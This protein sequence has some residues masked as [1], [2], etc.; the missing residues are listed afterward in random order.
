MKINTVLFDLDGVLI[1]TEH[2]YTEYWNN[3]GKKYGMSDDF[4][5]KVKGRIVQNI[6]DNEL[7]H[8]SSDDAKWLR[9]DVIKFDENIKLAPMKGVKEFVKMLYDNNFK[10]GLFT[11]SPPSKAK[12]ALEELDVIDFF[13]A[14]VSSGDIKNGKPDPEGYLLAAKRLNSKPEEC[15]VIEDSIM[16]IR[17]GR[18]AGMRVIGISSTL[19]AE[20]LRELKLAYEIIPGLENPESV[21]KLLD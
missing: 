15:V 2:L 9:K 5:M 8:I 7:A 14:M 19:P 6:I 13:G 10:I 18:A 11:S 3:V 20:E 21:L 1:D 4:G 17:S 16:G 12:R